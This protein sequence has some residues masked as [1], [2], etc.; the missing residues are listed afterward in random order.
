MELIDRYVA[1]VGRKLPAKMRPDIEKELRS[2][3]EDML[4]DR[5]Q[6]AGQPADEDMTVALLMEYGSPSQVAATYSA[7][8][9]LIGPALYPTY[10]MV[11]R[12]VVMALSI[13]AVVVLAVNLVFHGTSGSQIGGAVLASLS[14]LFNGSLT[15]LGVVTLIFAI[16]ERYNPNFKPDK[17]EWNPRELEPV[18][19][20]TNQI[21]TGEIIASIVF[22]VIAI[23]ILN[24]Y[25]D[26]IGIYYN[27]EGVWTMIPFLSEAFKVYVP[28]LTIL[29]GLEIALDVYLL[30]VGHWQ[31]VTRW[32]SIG[33]S[34]LSIGLLL[35]IINGPSIFLPS[36]AM[37]AAWQQA[38][39][40]AETIASLQ[41]AMGMSM[42][43]IIAIIIIVEL[44]DLGKQV[45]N[46]V[47][48]R[49]A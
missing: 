4:D 17:E 11:M 28:Y 5:A 40:S 44:V 48:S 12:V 19:K 32:L 26:R 20:P 31:P 36:A 27:T 35:V 49:E 14:I 33:H 46:L 29:C 21:K 16:N 24:L 7:P 13:A 22:N 8:R 1:E 18:V 37:F 43:I 23:I 45:W 41:M 9:Y 38:G 30:Q 34:F 25:Y 15:A 42:Q 3:L 10:V 2:I 6:A 47:R 39:M